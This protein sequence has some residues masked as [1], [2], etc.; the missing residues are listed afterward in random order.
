[1]TLFGCLIQRILDASFAAPAGTPWPAA[2]GV[3]LRANSVVLQAD[4]LAGPAY[5]RSSRR[6]GW[7]S[8]GSTTGALGAAARPAGFPFGGRLG[9]EDR[10]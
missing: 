3:I 4:E 9:G 1:M 10:H 2:A 5:E 6:R 8:D 7:L